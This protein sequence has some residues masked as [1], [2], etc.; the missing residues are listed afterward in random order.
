MAQKLQCLEGFSSF[1]EEYRKGDL[2]DLTVASNWPGDTLQNRIKNGFVKFT[3]VIVEAAVMAEKENE[4]FKTVNV[5]TAT[6][7]ELLEYARETLGAE[8]D[9]KLSLVALR[10]QVKALEADAAG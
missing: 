1:G 3:S 10:E 5:Y 9:A 6:K 7:A 2:I 8:L 4:K